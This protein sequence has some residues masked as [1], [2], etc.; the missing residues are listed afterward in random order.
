MNNILYLV[1]RKCNKSRQSNSIPTYLDTASTAY[2]HTEANQIHQYIE[3]EK[4]EKG[5]TRNTWKKINIKK[6]RQAKERK[7]KEN[8]V[9]QIEMIKNDTYVERKNTPEHEAKWISSVM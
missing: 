8:E 9:S 6:Q 7:A 1:R 5:R 3:G 2:V 4:H